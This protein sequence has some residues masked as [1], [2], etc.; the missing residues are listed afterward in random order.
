[1]PNEEELQ[2]LRLYLNEKSK[3]AKR[4][5]KRNVRGKKHKTLDSLREAD[6]QDL[7][8]LD[9]DP[10]HLK[11]ALHPVR[12]C[13]FEVLQIIFEWTVVFNAEYGDFSESRNDWFRAATCLSHVCR[14]WRSIALDTPKLWSKLPELTINPIGTDDNLFWE[15]TLSRVKGYPADLYIAG[16]S[17]LSNAAE[18]DAEEAYTTM[19]FH[20]IPH[21]RRLELV[22]D[23]EDSLEHLF[24][25]LLRIPEGTVDELQ[26]FGEPSVDVYLDGIRLAALLR[27]FPSLQSLALFALS[28]TFSRITSF[29]NISALE[30]SHVEPLMM[31]LLPRQFPNLQRLRLRTYRE[32]TSIS[33]GAYCFPALQEL[34]ISYM[35]DVY[36]LFKN[37]DCPKLTSFISEISLTDIIIDFIGRH[38][39]LKR[40][41]LSEC[42]LHVLAGIAPNV[43]DFT[44][45]Y[46]LSEPFIGDR[47]PAKAPILPQLEY[48]TLIDEDNTLDLEDFESMV[49][50]RALPPLDPQSQLHPG[51]QPLKA[52][53]IGISSELDETTWAKSDLYKRA[54]QVHFE[55]DHNV[56]GIFFVVMRW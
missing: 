19:R 14:R 53:A 31:E 16:F 12:R 45:P 56:V 29:R 33:T 9:C 47:D 21:I 38:P 22:L 40:I 3:Q 20:E 50:S 24:H 39:T 46:D 2:I 44:H 13:P 15:R 18:K 32:D 28:I 26:I 49:R 55:K 25:P 23:G 8:T 34:F 7:V 35:E 1:M 6:T 37:L 11:G 42:D 27:L 54:R 30:L 52:L 10:Q 17:E 5:K 41:R 43:T 36:G 51:C 4:P 48:Y